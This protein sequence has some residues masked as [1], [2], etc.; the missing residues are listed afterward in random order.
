MV[1]L[2]L[3]SV[4]ANRFSVESLKGVNASSGAQKFF[5]DFRLKALVV[6]H[7]K[8]GVCLI[9]F[10]RVFLKFGGVLGGGLVLL[11]LLDSSFSNKDLICDAKERAQLVTKII[12]VLN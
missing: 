4:K 2:V 12:V 6:H 5:A 9:E 3:L 8:G 1:K 11:K 7:Y 10:D